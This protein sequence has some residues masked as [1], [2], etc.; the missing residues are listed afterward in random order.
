MSMLLTTL[1]FVALTALIAWWHVRRSGTVATARDLRPCPRC[2]ARFETGTSLCPGCGVPLQ[3]YELVSAPVVDT[4]TPLETGVKPHPIVRTDVCVGCGTCVA[5]CPEPGALQLVAHHAVVDLDACV[6]HGTCAVA[7]P[8][9]AIVMTLGAAVQRVEVPDLDANFQSNVPGLYVVGE[10]GGRG[11][12]KNAIN[13]GRIAVEHVARVLAAGR[14]LRPAE[15]GPGGSEPDSPGPYDLLV[16][17]SG[18]AGLSA[19]LE[20]QRLG[21]RCVVLEQGSISDTIRKYPR[22]KLLLAEPSRVQLYGG[23]WVADASK[24]ELLAVWETIIARAGLRVR[25]GERV[26]ALE[27]DG[28]LFRVRTPGTEYQA[29]KVLLAMG[30]R[31]TPRRLGV[32]GE[33]LEKTLYDIV[34]MEAFPGCRMLVVGGGDS[35]IESALGLASQPD[36]TVTLSYRGQ[37]FPRLKARN[38]EKLEA[39]L[40][41]SGEDGSGRV[42]LLL[43]SR[44]VE[45]R[46]GVVVLDC[47]GMPRLLP[48]DYVVVR[49]GGEPPYPFIERCGV[50]I[51]TKE[52][53]IDT[54]A[55]RRAG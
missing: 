50:R 4:A 54:G 15:T 30:R 21:L 51:V 33:E 26:E 12:I 38:R 6:R 10:L 8:M 16:V 43:G 48:N 29:R 25:T 20:A 9:N 42:E 53:A 35:A 34:E 37:E 7:C 32:P 27:S 2:R 31:G 39:A 14:P 46:P 5:A 3:A 28:V 17:G 52:I 13:E 45:I 36:T 44:V 18:P 24:E 19:A 40:Q 22:R 47:A 49:V 23:L 55:E 41:A 11:L 1:A